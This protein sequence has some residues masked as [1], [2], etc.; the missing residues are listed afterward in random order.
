MIALKELQKIQSDNNSMICLGLDLDPRRMPSDYSRTT[1]GMFEFAYRIIE[2]T[3]DKVCAYKPIVAFYECLG[4]DG[5]SLLRLIVD[6]IPDDIPVIMDGKRGDVGNTAARYAEAMFDE[7]Q[8]DWVTLNPYLGYDSLRPFIERKDKGVFILCLTSNPGSRDFQ[9]LIVD[10]KPV[11]QIVAEKVSYWNKDHNC[12]LV[13][14][15]TVPE[16]LREIR[17]LAGDMP[18]LIPGVGA[19]GGSLEKAAAFGTADFTK[20]AVINVSRSVLYAGK[21]DDFAG[22][23]RSELE[24]LNNI[25]N[26]LRRGEEP[27]EQPDGTPAQQEA[28][29][30]E[31]QRQE[32]SESPEQP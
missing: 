28:S 21:D 31:P 12:G 26:A 5:L 27:A 7:L 20:T 8:A 19:Q 29:E 4:A 23:A 6:R 17:S 1:K 24:K 14:G 22:R 11:Y 2:A 9:M 25:I 30:Q 18:L 32:A 3:K 16:Q 13:V 15:A 10:G